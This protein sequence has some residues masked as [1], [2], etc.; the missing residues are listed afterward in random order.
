LHWLP[1]STPITD[2]YRRLRCA[3]CDERGAVEVDARHGPPLHSRYCGASQ[4]PHRNDDESNAAEQQDHQCP[5][6]GAVRNPL[7]FP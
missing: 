2:L 6:S 7:A 4:G 5:E 3:A 1:L